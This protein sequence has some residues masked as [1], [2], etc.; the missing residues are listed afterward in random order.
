MNNKNS[1]L[2]GRGIFVII[3]IVSFGLI[4]MNEKGGDLFKVKVEKKFETYLN[5]NYEDLLNTIK[6][7]KVNYK[8]NTFTQKIVSKK[9]KN[10]YFTLQYKNKEY[11]DTYQKDYVEGNSILNYLNN[12]VEKEIKDKYK[13]DCEVKAITTLDKYSEKVQEALLKEDNIINIRYYYIKKDLLISDWNK[14]TIT[15]EIVQT[16]K[17]LK[18]K[19][20]TPKYYEI[21]ITN[22]N[23]I[24][25]A[26]TL[27]NIN[28]S[29]I[30]RNDKEEIISDIL[31]G[32]ESDKVKE[33][34]IT[35][36]K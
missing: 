17:D 8:N 24:T 4:I 36:Q 33:S 15:N 23:D 22:E 20:I 2:I 7:D 34:K 35:F 31:N 16:I 11:S 6:K 10:W 3:I 18:D 26:I 9:N 25:E 29:F 32:K 5:D 14:E 19:N 12:K 13:I 27:S 30:D 1:L 28:E 21:S